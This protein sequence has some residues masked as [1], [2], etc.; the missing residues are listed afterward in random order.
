MGEADNLCDRIGI[1]NKGQLLC[2]DLPLKLKQG[3]GSGLVLSLVFLE[4]RTSQG[5]MAAIRK[6][7]PSPQVVKRSPSSLTLRI[8]IPSEESITFCRSLERE[9][10]ALGL[11]S[12]SLSHPGL[13]DVFIN[14]VQPIDPRPS[15]ALSSHND[16][17]TSVKQS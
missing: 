6:Y 13:D 8:R 15:L 17:G 2:A 10:E 3:L 16:R 7:D 9:K 11:Q 12:W 1:I 14:A 4:G 5:A